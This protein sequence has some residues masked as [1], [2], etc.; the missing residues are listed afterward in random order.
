MSWTRGLQRVCRQ[1]VAWLPLSSTSWHYWHRSVLWAHHY[2]R[3]WWTTVTIGCNQQYKKPMQAVSTSE[4]VVRKRRSPSRAHLAMDEPAAEEIPTTRPVFLHLK[5][6]QY[7]WMPSPEQ[8]QEMRHQM[9]SYN[10]WIPMTGGNQ[11]RVACSRFRKRFQFVQP[12]RQLYASHNW[13][14]V[15]QVPPWF[16]VGTC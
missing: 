15:F 5:Q 2:M 4:L 16:P 10:G 8:T 11:T 9:K 6:G 14:T 3:H 13:T 7:D 12:C 1:I